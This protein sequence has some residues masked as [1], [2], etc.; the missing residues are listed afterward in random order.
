M[1]SP[2]GGGGLH[3]ESVLSFYSF[4]SSDVSFSIVLIGI[5][6][7]ASLLSHKMQ[8]Q[9]QEAHAVVIFLVNPSISCVVYFFKQFHFSSFNYLSI[10]HVVSFCFHHST[11]SCPFS[12]VS[13][14]LYSSITYPLFLGFFQQFSALYFG[15]YSNNITN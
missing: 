9:Q 12:V 14:S 8:R 15:F 2:A 5:L 3:T 13:S 1:E 10:F 6:C 4:F 7:G 11:I